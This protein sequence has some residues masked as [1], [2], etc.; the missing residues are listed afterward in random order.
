MPRG[1]IYTAIMELGPKRPSPL[2][3]LGPNSIIVVYVDPLGWQELDPYIPSRIHPDPGLGHCPEP[4]PV[5]QPLL[6]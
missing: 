5:A 2:W 1:S 3:F 4:N 6:S